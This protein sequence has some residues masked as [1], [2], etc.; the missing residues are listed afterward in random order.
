MDDLRLL[1]IPALNDNYIWLLAD[2]SGNAMVVDPG[3]AAPVFEVLELQNL[4]LR[5]ILLT[6]H[7]PDHVGGVPE[8]LESG[9]ASVYAPVDPRIEH[10][11]HRVGDGDVIDLERPSCRFEVIAVPGHTRSH[12]AFHGNGLLFSGDTLF[13]V[14]CGRLFE[15]SPEQMLDSLDKL[16]RL[17]GDTRVCCG[18]EYTLANCNF[19]IT[20]EPGNRSLTRRREEAREL[21]ARGQPTVPSLLSDELA[22]NPFMR[23]D[24]DSV[25][26]GLGFETLDSS[27]RVTRFARLRGL[28]DTFRA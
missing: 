7:H 23:I 19:A 24:A 1:P 28:K 15:G 3:E 16:A 2:P 9:D 27:D 20:I 26:A 11:T 12:I 21:R 22:C 10:V 5:A 6:H 18:H 14:G 25:S 13:S 8:L 17:P 4:R